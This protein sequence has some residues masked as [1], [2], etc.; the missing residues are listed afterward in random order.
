MAKT[1]TPCGPVGIGSGGA[2]WM[3]AFTHLSAV[4]FGFQQAAMREV[5]T[6]SAAA[7][8]AQ[9]AFLRDLAEAQ[10]PEQALALT[11]AHVNRM[12]T[13]ATDLNT[14]INRVLGEAAGHTATGH[15]TPL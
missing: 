6:A 3:Q 12:M 5:L 13:G 8:E 9:A 7:M 2:D 14:R 15:A 1:P 10:S 11:G 4:P